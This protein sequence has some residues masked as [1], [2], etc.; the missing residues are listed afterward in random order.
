MEVLF[1]YRDCSKDPSYNP[2]YV[3]VHFS[4][5]LEEVLTKLISVIPG[6]VECSLSPLGEGRY[7][8]YF[9][10]SRMF[11]IEEIQTYIV[12][13]VEDYYSDEVVVTSE[14]KIIP[15]P[16]SQPYY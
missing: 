13:T 6:I 1:E 10:Y 7:C 9:T 8:L 11:N 4:V 5:E 14:I 2:Y 16:V 15:A 3:K 12:K